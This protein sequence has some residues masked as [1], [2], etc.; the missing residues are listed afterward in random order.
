MHCCLHTA[1]CSFDYLAS[2]IQQVSMPLPADQQSSHK[3]QC[4]LRRH[5]RRGRAAA[6]LPA[7]VDAEGGVNRGMLV[8]IC[9]GHRAADCSCTILCTLHQ[10]AVLLSVR[11]CVPTTENASMLIHPMPG[12]S[13]ADLFQVTALEEH[14]QPGP[15]A[16]RSRCAGR[17]PR[18]GAVLVQEVAVTRRY[19]RPQLLL[20]HVLHASFAL[21]HAL[22]QHNMD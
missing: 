13:R 11:C 17:A 6:A 2:M 3:A 21:A 5:C 12:T 10:V 14:V 22:V 8:G 15:A 1:G 16:E 7:A 9:T 18:C 19:H 20:R 4:P